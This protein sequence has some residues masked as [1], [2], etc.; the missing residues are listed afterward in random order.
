MINCE[1]TAAWLNAPQRSDG[2]QPESRVQSAFNSSI[3]QAA[4]KSRCC[5]KEL[6]F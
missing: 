3:P 2:D 5:P 4:L 1:L 6:S